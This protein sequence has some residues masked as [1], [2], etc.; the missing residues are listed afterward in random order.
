MEERVR[1][2]IF[3]LLLGTVTGS[4][5]VA[6]NWFTEPIIAA[7]EELRIKTSVMDALEIPYREETAEEVFDEKIEVF[8]REGVTY[9]RQ[10]EEHAVAFIFSGPG[11]WG[12]I[13]GVIALENDLET[14]RGINIVSQQ[15]TPGLGGRIGEEEFLAQFKG[16]VVLPSVRITPEGEA[17]REHEV[18]GI[19]GATETSRAL[20]SLLNRSIRAHLEI[21][22]REE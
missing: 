3:V 11:L 16:K 17:E 21:I 13:S 10:K 4:L 5:L 20:E 19:T 9:Y 1:V 8:T 18:D 6:V 12:P 2:I 14:I 7:R 15:E 22:R